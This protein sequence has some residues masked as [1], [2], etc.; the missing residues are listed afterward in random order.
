MNESGVAT[1]DRDALAAW[2]QEHDESC[3]NCG[4]TLRGL[5]SEICPECCALL[6][7]TVGASERRLGPWMTAIIGAALGLG[8]DATASILLASILFIGPAPPLSTWQPYALLGALA[9]LALACLFALILLLRARRRFARLPAS[10]QWRRA[11]L[12]F[13]TVG[14][15]H[16][17]AGAVLFMWLF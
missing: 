11:L 15:S 9:I 1:A 16:A 5:T 6:R 8:F 17:A 12:W 7:L 13:V 2:L 4:Y 3:P 14:A 10:A